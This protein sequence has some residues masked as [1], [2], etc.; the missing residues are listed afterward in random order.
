LI[1]RFETGATRDTSE[2]KYEYTRFLDPRVL[3]A[4]AAFMHRHRQQKDGSMREP[5]NWKLGFT[6]DSFMSSL[7]RHF[8]DLWELHD[9][10]H[11]YRPEDGEPANLTETLCAIIFNAHGWLYEHL[12]SLPQPK[13][14]VAEE[15][16]EAG[17]MGREEIRAK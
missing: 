14:E 5:D 3:K 4:Y 9:Y 13:L 11:S 7:G 10:G 15:E 16:Y 12:K 17:W 2:G 8:M 1:R 6:I